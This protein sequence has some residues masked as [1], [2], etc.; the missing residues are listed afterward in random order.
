MPRQ[1]GLHDV[2]SRFVCF[3]PRRVIIALGGPHVFPLAAR[4]NLWGNL[5][6]FVESRVPGYLGHLQHRQRLQI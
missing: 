4:R 1:F 3:S 2:F 6:K 5:V